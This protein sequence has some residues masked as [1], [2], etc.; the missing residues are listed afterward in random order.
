MFVG[1]FLVSFSLSPFLSF[2]V[3]M[4]VLIWF[5]LRDGYVD[6]DG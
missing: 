4:G 5:L 3:L 1:G 6:L 2:Y